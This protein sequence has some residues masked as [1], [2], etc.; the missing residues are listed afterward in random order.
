M[1]R[2]TKTIRKAKYLTFIFDI[3][4]FLA[5][6]FFFGWAEKPGLLM[7]MDMQIL[8]F[9]WFLGLYAFRAF[10][11]THHHNSHSIII[12]IFAGIT[13]GMVFSVLPMVLINEHPSKLSLALMYVGMFTGTSLIHGFMLIWI[14]QYMEPERTIVI[15]KKDQWGAMVQQLSQSISYKL[16]PVAYLNPSTATLQQTLDADPGI[17][18]IL[19]ADQPKIYD[20]SVNTMVKDL[21]NKGLK[22]KFIPGVA[23]MTLHR[24]P[25]NIAR[26]YEQYYD[27]FFNEVEPSSYKRTFDIFIALSSLLILSPL[28]LVIAVLIALTSGFPVIYRQKRIGLY[29]KP[30]T[31][32]KFRSMANFQT[33]QGPAFLQ[34]DGEDR[35]TGFGKLLR[36]SRL[37][38]LP[39][40]WNV[41][42]GN[43]SIVG[44]RPEM[45]EFHQKGIADIP[46]YRY[47]TRL[48]P[49]ITGWAQVNFNHT[50][51]LDDYKRKTEYDLYYVKNRS[52]LLDLQVMLLTAETM[53]GMKGSR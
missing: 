42:I 28:M 11:L 37:D 31:I 24:I 48:R 44:P 10:D 36:K 6:A 3:C 25:L 5:L 9:I 12:S 20:P 43:M 32:H 22:V 15:G 27:I 2:V 1:I 47:R 21:I 40:L 41:L 35:I 34:E 8:G 46:F 26:K 30:F 50:T 53:L 39:Q 14:R 23:E 16:K 18:T 29:E 52:I 17:S 7:F 38:E 49:G 51:N 45:P 19:I 4:L 13:L 33:D